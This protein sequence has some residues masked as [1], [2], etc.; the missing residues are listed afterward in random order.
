MNKANGGDGIPVELFQILKDDVVQV[1]HSIYQQIWKTQQWHRTGKGVFIPV[2][3]KSNAKW[4]FKLALHLFHM[5]A[6]HESEVAQS[7]PTL[8]D[9]ME[10]SLLGSSLQ[11]ILQARILEWVAISFSRG[12]S[13]PRDRTQVSHIAGRCFNLWATRVARLYSKSFKLGF[14]STQTKNF[15]MYSLG[16]K[17]AEEAEIKLPTFIGT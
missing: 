15:Q 11:G 2:P 1:L 3:K 5:L 4:M 14:S 13:Q 6:K 16:L 7:C 10:C 17:K 9:P 8:C 12:A